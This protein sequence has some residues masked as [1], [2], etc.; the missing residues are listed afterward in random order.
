MEEAVRP[1]KLRD[2]EVRLRARAK[3]GRIKSWQLAPAIRGMEEVGSRSEE[4]GGGEWKR[5]RP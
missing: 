4:E 1:R 5:R 2:I 3:V